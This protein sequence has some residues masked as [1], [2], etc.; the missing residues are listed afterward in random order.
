[1]AAKFPG[2]PADELV[3][4]T[5]QL[6]DGF[7][8]LDEKA[9]WFRIE[10]IGKHGLPKTIDKVLAVAGEVTVAQL[11]AAMARNRRLWK[12][13]PP[14]NVLLEFCRHDAG[15]ARRGRPHHRRSAARL[16]EG[17]DRRR[18][19]AGRA[20][21]RSTARSWNAARWKTSASATA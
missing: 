1:M 12:E 7:A 5:L 17:A 10:G 11:R 13:P 19:E 16:A 6:I 8:W 2:A 4:E 14:E 18:A 9:G 20:C 15:R 21:S 3:A